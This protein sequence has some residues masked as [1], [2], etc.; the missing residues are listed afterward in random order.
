VGTVLGVVTGRAVWRVFANQLHVVPDPTVPVA[1]V[2]A[3]AVALIV[4]ANL[5]ALPV[6]RAAGRTPAAVTLRTE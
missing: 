1:A 6:G 2:I 3:A 5:V 4:A